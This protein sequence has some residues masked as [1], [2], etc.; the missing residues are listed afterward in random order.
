MTVLVTFDLDNTLWDVEPV[1]V[2]ANHA[3]WH[4][5]E[6]KLPGFNQAFGNE[7]LNALK[8][9]LLQEFDHL[10]ADISKLRIESYRL[11]LV[12]FGLTT[13]AAQQLAEDAFQFFHQWRQKVDLYPEAMTTLKH[14]SQHYRLAVITNGNADVFH[15]HIGLGE[16]F[17]FAIRADQVGVAKPHADIFHQAASRA[18]VD[19]NNII[20]IGDHPS[21]DVKGV[22]D[23]GGKSIWFNRHGAR[24]WSSDWEGLPDVEVHALEELLEAVAKLV[25]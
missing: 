16:V 21:D 15:E 13:K 9:A 18:K 11:A 8:M 22:N 25:K 10:K 19:V 17:E 4:W 3:M 23:V 12:E 14:L 24:K 7:E 6:D 1:I 2:R 20:H 5:F